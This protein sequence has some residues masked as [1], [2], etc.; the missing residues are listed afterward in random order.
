MASNVDHLIAGTTGGVLT[1]V[2]L[3]PLDLVKTRFQVHEGHIG[4]AKAGAQ[5]RSTWHAF[6]SIIADEGVRGVYKGLG[7]AVV[8]SGISWGLYFFFYERAKARNK[9]F[10]EGNNFW[11]N[12][13]F[14]NLCS[15]TEAGVITVFMT[16]PIWLVKT[17]MQ[18]QVHLDV[19]VTPGLSKA[20][21][22]RAPPA[23]GI[24][25]DGLPLYRNMGDAFL[26]IMRH[27]GFFA[28]YRGIVPALFLVS[29]GVLQFVAYE[30]LKS[31]V[32]AKGSTEMAGW[33]PL[34]MGATSKIM[35]LSATYP[36]QVI[37]SRIQQRQLAGSEPYNSMLNCAQRIWAG[38]GI[39]GFYKG[40]APN[41]MR[42]APSAAITFFTYENIKKLLVSK[43]QFVSNHR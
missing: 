27:E 42:I 13:T 30:E 28:L 26:S 40:L 5:Y 11:N 29:H 3:H 35:A 25:H 34:V 33:E 32:T 2:S 21:G 24:A 15:S 31:I 10:A 38:E 14:I 20:S 43:K 6:R 39:R 7:P 36:W 37:K 8:G 4:R 12:F 19:M 9:Q 18:L 22:S 41:C 17:R 1:T 16:N 23:L